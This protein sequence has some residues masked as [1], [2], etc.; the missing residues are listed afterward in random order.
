[1]DF[2]C[3]VE[4]PWKAF[5]VP[6]GVSFERLLLPLRVILTMSYQVLDTLQDANPAAPFIQLP[7][8]MLVAIF[9]EVDDID[10]LL[11]HYLA[12]ASLKLLPSFL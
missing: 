10:S 11:S 7:T 8:E 3:T 5:T 9:N 6:S 4:W 2:L 12:S 1:M